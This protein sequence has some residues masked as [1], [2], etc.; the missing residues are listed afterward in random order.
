MEQE[1]QNIDL[2]TLHKFLYYFEVQTKKHIS[3]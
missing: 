3:N 1:Y 2:V